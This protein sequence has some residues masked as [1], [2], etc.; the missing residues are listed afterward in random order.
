[1]MRIE[2]RDQEGDK[3][4]VIGHIE[5]PVQQFAIPGGAQEWVTIR[6]NG[7]VAGRVHF[8]SHFIRDG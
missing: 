2:V 4:P 7:E 3:Q 8:R 6:H 1:M 5:L